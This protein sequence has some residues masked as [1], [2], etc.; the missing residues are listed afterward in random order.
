ML[1]FALAIDSYIIESSLSGDSFY[2]SSCLGAKLSTGDLL[3]ELVI[4]KA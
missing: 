2:F 4:F 1:V 3:G